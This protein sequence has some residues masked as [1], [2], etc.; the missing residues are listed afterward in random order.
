MLAIN[1]SVS[2]T[3]GFSPAF[4]VQGRE[5]RLPGALYDEV[6]QGNGREPEAPEA[7]ALR[8]QD[9][10]RTAKE[11]TQR[12]TIDQARHSNLRRREWCPE[13]HSLVPAKHHVLSNAADGFAA[14]LAPKYEG[15][16]YVRKFISPNVV[17][18]QQVG[19]SRRRVANLADLKAYHTELEPD[20]QP[21]TGP[22][23]SAPET[24]PSLSNSS[25]RYSPNTNYMAS[26]PDESS[27]AEGN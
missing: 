27:E 11:N 24:T 21:E 14:K 23:L 9:I 8:L 10:F 6:T 20:A 13:L 2:H 18:L 3:T 15:P 25:K 26:R 1:T 16:Y 5:P 4:L 19:T 22:G 7:K 17:R 12:A